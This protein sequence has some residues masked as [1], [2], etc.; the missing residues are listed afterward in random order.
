MLRVGLPRAMC[1]PWVILTAKMHPGHD[2]LDHWLVPQGMDMLAKK[3]KRIGYTKE[4]IRMI[5]SNVHWMK[6]LSNN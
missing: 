2:F 6:F 1:D 5:L 3:Q 4:H